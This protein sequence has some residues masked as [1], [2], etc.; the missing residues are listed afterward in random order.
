MACQS[1]KTRINVAA[2]QGCVA[3]AAIAGPLDCMGTSSDGL[4]KCTAPRISDFGYG[5]CVANSLSTTINAESYCASIHYPLTGDAKI[6]DNINCIYNRL[7][8][9]SRTYVVP[10]I[11]WRPDGSTDPEASFQCFHAEVIWKYG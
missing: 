3:N 1:R 11:Q 8:H 4:A 5:T 2:T 10:P 7:N 6:A 9:D